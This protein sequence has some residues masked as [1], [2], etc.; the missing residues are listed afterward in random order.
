MLTTYKIKNATTK[1]LYLC[2]NFSYLAYGTIFI[3]LL[4]VKNI[5][6]M[7]VLFLLNSAGVKLVA[8]IVSSRLSATGWPSP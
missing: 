7:F 6:V 2:Y 8:L 1:I 5:Y 3:T 4:K